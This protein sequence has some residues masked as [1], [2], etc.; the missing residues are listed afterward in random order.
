M[1]KY[2]RISVNHGVLPRVAEEKE[3][4]SVKWRS[5]HEAP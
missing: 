4:D 2:V 5:G 1:K 3:N